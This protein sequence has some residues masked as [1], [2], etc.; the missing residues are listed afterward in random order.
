M[1]GQSAKQAKKNIFFGREER[2]MKLAKI[3]L[4]ISLHKHHI[5]SERRKKYIDL[6]NCCCVPEQ[7]ETSGK[8]K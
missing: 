8:K 7:F 4:Y 6:E 1:S 5:V 2:E 3:F